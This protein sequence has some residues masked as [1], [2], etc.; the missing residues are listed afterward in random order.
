MNL[1]LLRNATLRLEL[2]GQT[3][4]I[5]PMLGERHTLPSFGGLEANPT[6][7]LPVP[8]DAALHGERQGAAPPGLNAREFV[9][10]SVR[11]TVAEAPALLDAAQAAYGRVPVWVVGSSMG[12]Y[13]AQTLARTEARVARAAALITSGVWHEPEVTRPDLQ[14]FLDRHRPLEHAANAVPTPLF[15]GSGGADPVFP[16]ETHHAPTLAA[17]RAAYASAGRPNVLRATVYPG[18]G[19]YTS[20]RMRD[21]T[22]AFLRADS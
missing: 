22:L 13:I 10:E 8:P 21:D 2:A 3:V 18:V 4:L 16:L 14:A 15:L 19:H 6:V 20:R 1:T 7:P 12:G 9:W 5:D 11:R 17:Y